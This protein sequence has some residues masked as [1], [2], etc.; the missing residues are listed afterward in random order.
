[1]IT[2]HLI[3]GPMRPSSSSDLDVTGQ[4]L[5]QAAARAVPGLSLAVVIG[6][7]LLVAYRMDAS[8]LK[9]G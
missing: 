6:W 7:F 8:A 1:M 2:L 9:E 3:A 5:L 4:V